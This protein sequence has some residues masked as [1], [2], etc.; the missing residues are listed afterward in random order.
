MIKKTHGRYS[1]ELSQP[2][3][4]DVDLCCLDA[5]KHPVSRWFDSK[6]E[7]IWS[8]PSSHCLPAIGGLV[9]ETPLQ[10]G[11]ETGTTASTKTGL[12]HLVQDPVMALE[13]NLFGLVP[14]T[15]L[16]SSLELVVV[17]SINVGEDAV[18]V[19]QVAEGGTDWWNRGLG[20]E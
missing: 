5:R 17:E 13:K 11:G 7:Q 9:H 18:L 14:V 19:L 16:E 6:K 1:V 12:F 3:L 8:V 2:E 15:T 4:S 10:S 20:G